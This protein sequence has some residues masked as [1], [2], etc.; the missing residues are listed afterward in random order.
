VR[1]A[2]P[3]AAPVTAAPDPA[4]AASVA[5][6]SRIEQLLAMPPLPGAPEF[7]KRR[8]LVL[9]RAR[10]EP[11]VFV[12]E[13]AR[14]SPTDLPAKL[15]KEAA[16]LDS[17]APGGRV[18]TIARRHPREPAA[19]RS[20]LLREG[21]VYAPDPLDALALVAQLRI[22]DLFEEP[23]V[24]LLRRSTI[25]RLQRSVAS[26]ARCQ[27]A[28]CP[29]SMIEYRYADGPSQGRSVD[30][31]FGDRYA[32]TEAGL[33]RP[34]HRDFRT[35]LKQTGASRVRISH[36][37]DDAM[38]ADL[39]FGSA[40]YTAVIDARAAEVS[41]G[42]IAGSEVE[43]EALAA[44]KAAN[45]PRIEVAARIERALDEQ[46]DETLRFDRPEG[47]KHAELD[48][49]LRPIWWDAY[50]RKQPYFSYDKVS[51]PVYD[52][53]GRAWPPQ[54]CVDLVLDTFERASGTWFAAKGEEPRRNVGGLDFNAYGIPNRRGVLAFEA[55]A[56]SKP[57]LFEV[58]HFQGPERIQFGER[59]RFFDFLVE[60]A[61]EFQPG[62]V[63]AIHGRKQDG[64][65]HQ[66][67]IFIESMDPLT[68]FPYGLADQMKRP[69]RRTWEGIMAEAPLRSLLYR[70]RPRDVVL[71]MV[72]GQKTGAQGMEEPRAG[73]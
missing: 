70:V 49:K 21:Y 35:L 30:L 69:R 48:G 18:V 71:E 26:G 54:V 5:C 16:T 53:K 22:A 34:L 51:Y 12:R 50:K 10:G 61:D 13:P 19:L 73:N 72:T 65:I 41:I 39:R 42:C 25:S 32:A 46:V 60:H 27:L 24:W 23:E 44:W 52:A 36:A 62:D 29:P 1:P 14:T 17:G 59:T 37:T 67:A 33:D 66:H 43:R 55:F 8:H 38:V 68:G 7:D 57:D 45:R 40:W 3:A 63:V 28:T 15:V 47:V 58:R 56:S 9:G 20:L 2:A 11:M 6:T 4:Q 64:L 31:L